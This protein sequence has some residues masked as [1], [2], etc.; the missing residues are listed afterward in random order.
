L[1]G[2]LAPD[3]YLYDDLT[4]AENLRFIL[5]MAGRKPEPQAIREALETVELSAHTRE[6]MRT[7][8]SG[9]KR[10]LS[11]ARLMLLEPRLLLLD[12]PYNSLDE[13]A[14]DLVDALVRRWC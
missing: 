6:R 12:E 10:R 5:T 8:S 11:L 1:V 13:R 4:A 9:M 14:A 3:T 2:L 7:F